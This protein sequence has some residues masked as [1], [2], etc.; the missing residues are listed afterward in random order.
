[1][2]T[3]V[4]G[5]STEISEYRLRRGGRSARAVRRVRCGEE[6]TGYSAAGRGVYRVFVEVFADLFD[7]GYTN[8]MEAE[9]D[10][11]E[12]AVNGDSHGRDLRE[13]VREDA[14]RYQ[15]SADGDKEH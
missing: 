14:G 9:L 13:S 5:K 3:N 1:V 6:Q 7:Y 2:K 11:I 4:A 10:K 8:T 15:E 12:Y